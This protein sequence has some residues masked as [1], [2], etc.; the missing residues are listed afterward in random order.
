MWPGGRP[1][2]CIKA[3]GVG[4]R[5]GTRTHLA[6]NVWLRYFVQVP[7]CVCF[8][9]TQQGATCRDTKSKD[10]CHVLC[11]RSTYLNLVLKLAL[12]YLCTQLPR[13]VPASPRQTPHYARSHRYFVGFCKIAGPSINCQFNSIFPLLAT[14][15]TISEYLL[16]AIFR[17]N[18]QYRYGCV[19]Y[20]LFVQNTFSQSSIA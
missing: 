1:P 10:P 20:F 3:R 14:G 15:L 2:G 6:I 19:G 17:D 16:S 9:T 11:T 18:T 4:E 7:V 8:T 12:C 5:R 13:Y